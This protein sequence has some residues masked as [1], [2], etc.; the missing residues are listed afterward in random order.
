MRTQE[1]QNEYLQNP[2]TVRRL[3]YVFYKVLKRKNDFEDFYHDYVVHILEGK[4]SSQTLDQFGIEWLRE[5]TFYNR[6]KKSAPQ[7]CSFD[8]LK[9]FNEAEVDDE[10]YRELI[11]DLAKKYSGRYRMVIFLYYLHGMNHKELGFL[12]NITE[13]R[14]SQIL[15]TIKSGKRLKNRGEYEEYSETEKTELEKLKEENRLL[16]N[17]LARH[18]RDRIGKTI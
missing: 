2:E 5:K 7:F 10:T 17:K 15:S 16:S 1:E 13:S 8:L 18:F 6:D 9:N 11:L 4:G 14:I 3:K 12:L